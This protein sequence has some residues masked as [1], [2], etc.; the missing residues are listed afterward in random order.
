MA[1]PIKFKYDQVRQMYVQYRITFN[2]F[3]GIFSFLLKKDI[4]KIPLDL[5]KP[6]ITYYVYHKTLMDYKSNRDLGTNRIILYVVV[7]SSVRT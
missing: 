6:N 3:I 5:K 1:K 2:I 4:Y 7:I